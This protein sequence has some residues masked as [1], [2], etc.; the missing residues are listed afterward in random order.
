MKLPKQS[1]VILTPFGERIAQGRPVWSI[2]CVAATPAGL[3]DIACQFESMYTSPFVILFFIF[4]YFKQ[5][6]FR[7]HMNLC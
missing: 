7:P 4:K 1:E 6:I 5:L 3:G 2:D